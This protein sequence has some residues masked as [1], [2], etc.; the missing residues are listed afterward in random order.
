MLSTISRRD[1]LYRPCWFRGGECPPFWRDPYVC[2]GWLAR[3]GPKKACSPACCWMPARL[4]PGGWS[5][6]SSTVRRRRPRATSPGSSPAAVLSRTGWP[7]AWLT[8]C[9]MNRSIQPFSLRRWRSSAFSTATICARALTPFSG[10]ATPGSKGADG[11]TINAMRQL[12]ACP[13]AGQISGVSP[14]SA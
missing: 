1:E 10:S 4:W 14:A 11:Q 2:H 7:R 13:I 8:G 6:R 5:K 12:F 3:A 9:S